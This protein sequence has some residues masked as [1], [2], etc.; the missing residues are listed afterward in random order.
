MLLSY[1]GFNT[2]SGVVVIAGTNRPDVLDQ[3]LLRPGRFDRII[4]LDPPDLKVH[5]H[6]LAFHSTNSLLF[7]LSS[8][9]F[10]FFFVS[11]ELSVMKMTKFASIKY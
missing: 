10:H 3:A 2:T 11:F 7:S 4:H 6:F 8:L 5:S 1:S 9:F